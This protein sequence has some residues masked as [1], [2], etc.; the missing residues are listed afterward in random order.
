[1]LGPPESSVEGLSA[2]LNLRRALVLSDTL[3]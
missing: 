3:S 2:D 1:L